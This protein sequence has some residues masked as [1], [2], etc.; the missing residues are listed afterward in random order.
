[1]NRHN[2]DICALSETKKKGNARYNNYILFHSGVEKNHRAQAG[3]GILIHEKFRDLIEKVEYVNQYLMYIT[4]KLTS[5]RVHMVSV[6]AD[7]NKP[8]DEREHFFDELQEVLER[9]PNRNNIFL[10]GD[11]NSRIGNNHILGVMQRFNEETRNENGD[12]LISF[13]AQNELCI[14]N[15]FFDYRE[16]QKY[17]FINTRGQKSMIDHVITN[18]AIYP[19]RVLDVRT[20]VSANV[21]TKHGLVLCKYRSSHEGRKK[22]RPAN[23]VHKF[24]TEAFSNDSTKILYQNRLREKIIANPHRNRYNRRSRRKIKKNIINSAKEAIE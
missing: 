13:Y 5:D 20:L 12:M 14:N 1:M 3:V 11:F 22:K 16:Q 7:M 9:L 10:M 24:N 19:S 4:I 18:R 21:G 2:I 23:Y 15:T 6:Y 17:T 8:R